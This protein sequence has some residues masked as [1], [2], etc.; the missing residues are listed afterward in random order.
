MLLS[1]RR[2]RRRSAICFSER[3]VIFGTDEDVKWPED[4]LS[5]ARF[6]VK[7]FSP[8]S[9]RFFYPLQTNPIHFHP[10]VKFRISS[11]DRSKY[12]VDGYPHYY[13]N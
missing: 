5:S 12:F 13:E 3:T 10:K 1:S 11:R 2:S 6:F 9:V 8:I 7:N 4:I